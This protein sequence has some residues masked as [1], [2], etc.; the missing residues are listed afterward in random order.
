MTSG[1]Q[2]PST[3]RLGGLRTKELEDNVELKKSATDLKREPQ[4][5]SPQF[6]SRPE[7]QEILEGEEVTFKCKGKF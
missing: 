5:I 6:E 1:W 2:A 4:G 3:M 7:S